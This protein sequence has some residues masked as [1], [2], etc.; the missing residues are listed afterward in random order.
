M[1]TADT[2]HQVAMW[3]AQPFPMMAALCM[4][5]IESMQFLGDYCDDRIQSLSR[6]ENNQTYRWL[7]IWVAS[8]ILYDRSAPPP[9]A[10]VKN[11]PVKIKR[12]IKILKRKSN[13]VDTEYLINCMRYGCLNY[14]G[15]ETTK[16]IQRAFDSNSFLYNVLR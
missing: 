13:T 12:V 6:I 9:G 10:F 8:V 15:P 16:G 2:A 11:S 14:G 4:L 1:I 5:P 7:R 3:L